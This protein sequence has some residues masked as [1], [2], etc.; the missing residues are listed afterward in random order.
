MGKTYAHAQEVIGQIDQLAPK[1]LAME[2]DPI[3]L[4]VGSLQKSIKKV[5]VTLDVIE[6]VIDEAIEKEIDLII[7]HHPLIYKPLKRIN[8]DTSH[9]RTIQKLLKHEITLYTAHTNLDVATGGV[10]DLLA[11]VIGIVN[12]NVLVETAK[13][14]LKKIVVFV[15]KSH[16]EQVREA[17]GE[18][19]A[20]YIGNY[21][22]CT[23]NTPG[24]GMFMPHEGTNPHIGRK[25]ILEQVDEVKIESIYPTSIEKDVLNAM[26]K[27]H[28]YEE[29]AHDIFILDN[30]GKSLGIGRIGELKDEMTLKALAEHLKEVLDVEGLR[31]VGNPAQLVK[32]VAVSGGEG[33]DFISQAKFKGAD[34]FISGDIKYHYA[35]D[36]MLEGPAIIDPGHNVEKVMK[37]GVAAYIKNWLQHKK[38]QT[39]VVESDTETDPFRFL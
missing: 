37:K 3:G 25:D 15:P 13:D 14:P 12:T 18:A 29:V 20:G 7:A 27:A 22:H 8:P 24:T 38:Y 36:A 10:N 39:E 6:P 16:A 33:N 35:H 23:F 26:K 30:P 5:M 17:L 9:G 4:Q 28:P 32:K 31:Y 19:G 21:S 1:W 34:V 2:G 11:D